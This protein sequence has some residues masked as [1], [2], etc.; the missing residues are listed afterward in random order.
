MKILCLSAS[1]I[2]PAREHSVSTRTCELIREMIQADINA[3]IDILCL[4]NYEMNP[5]RMCGKCLEAG[6]CVRDDAFNQ[7]YKKLADAD[8]VFVVCP[9]Y[10]PL[11]SKLMMLLEKMEEICYLNWCR[12]QDYQTVVSKKPIGLVAH[13][14]Q[15]TETALY[16]K[17]ALLDPLALSFAS[18][19][20]KVIGAGEQSPN[21]VFFGIKD[22]RLVPDS[23]FV[24]IEHD[25]EDIRSRLRPLVKNVLS[26]VND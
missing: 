1:N 24:E 4:I 8:A 10:A 14:G 5:C 21:G 18:I 11:P 3:H 20:M 7:I 22:L 26:Q 9:H 13:G 12:N 23:I 25:W 6:K 16:Y 19:Q 17:T 15:P 2:E